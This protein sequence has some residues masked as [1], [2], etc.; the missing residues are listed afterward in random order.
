MNSIHDSEASW[1]GQRDDKYN[2][3]YRWFDGSEFDYSNWGSEKPTRYSRK[4]CAIMTHNGEGK[5]IPYYCNSEKKFFLQE[6][7]KPFD[8]L[9]LSLLFF[10]RWILIYHSIIKQDLPVADK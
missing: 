1:I 7:N 10:T 8:S 5:W 9:S 3:E 2:L 6:V 4:H